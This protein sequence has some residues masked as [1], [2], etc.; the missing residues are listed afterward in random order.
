M[1]QRDRQSLKRTPTKGLR[2]KL[3]IEL[4]RLGVKGRFRT[5]ELRNGSLMV[6]GDGLGPLP[7]EEFEGKSIHYCERKVSDERG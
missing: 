7:I 4:R 5:D 3:R 6:E 2:Q 1:K